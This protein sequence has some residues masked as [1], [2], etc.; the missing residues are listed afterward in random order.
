[1]MLLFL[2]LLRRHLL[3]FVIARSAFGVKCTRAIS[4]ILVEGNKRRSNLPSIINC[5]E[6][7][8]QLYKNHSTSN[9]V[10]EIASGIQQ[11]LAEPTFS[12]LL[13][14]PYNDKGCFYA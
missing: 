1:M 9:Q 8:R 2:R 13:T 3:E 4:G 11:C 7:F 12:A 14:K 6:I 10:R 5:L